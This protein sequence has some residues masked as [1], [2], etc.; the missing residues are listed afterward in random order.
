MIRERW[1]SFETVD[2]RHSI[3]PF[4]VSACLAVEHYVV[5]PCC[6]A[7]DRQSSRDHFGNRDAFVLAVSPIAESADATEASLAMKRFALRFQ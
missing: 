2:L 4:L 6:S 7:R 3:L 1:E 5:L